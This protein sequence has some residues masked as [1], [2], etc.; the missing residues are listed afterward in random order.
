MTSRPWS[1]PRPPRPARWRWST[2]ATRPGSTKERRYVRSLRRASRCCPRADCTGRR[3]HSCV[4][5]A[6]SSQLVPGRIPR[7]AGFRRFA[8]LDR[9]AGAYG[10]NHR[11]SEV[12]MS[13]I[14]DKVTGKTKQAVGDVIGDRSLHREGRKEER[15]GEAKEEHA[16]AE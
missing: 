1:R 7:H 4:K 5:P 11:T 15:K 14:V 8:L 16:R 13:D 12:L 2:A 9:R 3:P 6:G 10:T